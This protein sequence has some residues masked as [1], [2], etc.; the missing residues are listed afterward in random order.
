MAACLTRRLHPQGVGRAVPT[1]S[2]VTATLR[3]EDVTND[4]AGVVYQP[5]QMAS[6]STRGQNFCAV[7]PRM[8]ARA[9]IFCLLSSVLS[10]SVAEDFPD[11]TQPPAGI[12]AVSSGQGAAAVV[13]GQTVSPARRGLQSIIISPVRRAA[14]INGETVELG[15]KAGR[16]K[17]V[18]VSESGVVLQGARGRQVLT[19]FPG[20]W[21]K[22]RVAVPPAQMQKKGKSANEAVEYAVPK[23][24]K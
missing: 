3:T 21:M 9:S 19:L 14:I 2:A 8:F 13:V 4:L 11:P 22:A 6:N 16:S 12:N 1:A 5:G 24:E 17:L 15:E 20:V 7:T 18:E 10:P 23:E